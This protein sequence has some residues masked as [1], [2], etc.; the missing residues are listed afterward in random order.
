MQP[1]DQN[2]FPNLP[3]SIENSNAIVITTERPDPTVHLRTFLAPLGSMPED[4]RVIMALKNVNDV[5]IEVGKQRQQLELK[6]PKNTL[7]L[8]AIFKNKART[9]FGGANRSM[10]S[11]E[12]VAHPAT[13]APGTLRSRRATIQPTNG[14]K[15]VEAFV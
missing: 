4:N 8:S 7:P 15:E 12:I 11:T 3:R 6:L 2:P 13:A 1:S 9:P 10:F 14:K 5:K